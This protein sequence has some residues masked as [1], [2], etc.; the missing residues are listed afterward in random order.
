MI[1]KSPLTPL[2]QRGDKMFL[3]ENPVEPRLKSKT[4][5]QDNAHSLPISYKD[6]IGECQQIFDRD[7]SLTEDFLEISF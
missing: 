6:R 2:C 7:V 4:R 1:K 5:Y 3:T